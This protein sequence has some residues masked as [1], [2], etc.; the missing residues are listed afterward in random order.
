MVCKSKERQ[1]SEAGGRKK[2][3]RKIASQKEL[4]RRVTH[5]CLLN[6]RLASEKPKAHSTVISAAVW[7]GMSISLSFPALPASFL[8]LSVCGAVCVFFS[9]TKHRCQEKRQKEREKEKRT[10]QPSAP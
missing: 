3:K 8:S 7:F 6:T 4:A 9:A 5:V 2:R 10:R 1:H